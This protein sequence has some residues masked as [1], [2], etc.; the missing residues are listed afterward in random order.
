[1]NMINKFTVHSDMFTPQVLQ[2]YLK[3]GL[4]VSTCRT[5]EAGVKCFYDFCVFVNLFNLFPLT[6]KSL[7]YFASYLATQDLSA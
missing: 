3:Q 5:Y 1:M 2:I 6:E 4:A 7:C